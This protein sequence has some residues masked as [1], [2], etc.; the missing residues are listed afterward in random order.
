MPEDMPT[1]AE[2]GE[3][4][5]TNTASALACPADCSG[6]GKCGDDEDGNKKCTCS[7]GYGG[8][9]CATMDDEFDVY[10]TRL[11]ASSQSQ[12]FK[13]KN[14]LRQHKLD[15][16]NTRIGA[17]QS[18][19]DSH[20]AD[21][22]RYVDSW[23]KR[24]MLFL[25]VKDHKMQAMR[26]AVSKLQAELGCTDAKGCVGDNLRHTLG[27]EVKEHVQQLRNDLKQREEDLET[28]RNAVKEA[29][30]KLVDTV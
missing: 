27:E 25:D 6:H 1:A 10:W 18:R 22:H 16:W 13:G 9:D 21:V 3:V 4:N 26:D 19:F 20:N 11:M 15:S 28:R 7:P 8:E 12:V 2:D 24:S 17:M 23:F 14:K 29:R 5:A 30:Q